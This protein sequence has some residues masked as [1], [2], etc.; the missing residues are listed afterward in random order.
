MIKN[1]IIY[2]VLCGFLTSC[3]NPTKTIKSNQL[4][5]STNDYQQPKIVRPVTKAYINTANGENMIL[6]SQIS[7]NVQNISLLDAI[8][9]EKSQINVIALDD[10][11]SLDKKIS[12]RAN[13]IKFSDYLIQLGRITGYHLTLDDNKVIIASRINQTWNLAALA[14]LPDAQSSIKNKSTQ[15]TQNNNS[16]RLSGDK[17]WLGIV[18]NIN[19]LLDNKTKNKHTAKILTNRRLGTISVTASPDDIS[20]VDNYLQTV[21][22]S[23]NKQI[24]LEITVLDVAIDE[25]ISSGIDFTA[26]NT[27]IVANLQLG[28]TIKNIKNIQSSVNINGVLNLLNTHGKVKIISKP[29]ITLTNGMSSQFG[30]INDIRFISKINANTDQS[31]NV[32]Q[33]SEFENLEIGLQMSVVVRLIDDKRVLVQLVPSV[34]SVVSSTNVTTGSGDNQQTF[35]LPNISLQSLLTQVIVEDGQSIVVGGLVSNKVV[36]NIKSFDHNLFSFL[37][38]KKFEKEHREIFFLVKATILN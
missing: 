3:G 16:I 12:I 13:K 21:I 31:G 8:T 1:I 38:G 11:V 17:E 23:A 10:G 36:D 4:N 34:S 33:T 7:I 29:L 19:L 20:Q 14:S 28:N 22:K 15:N 2:I 25:D 18:N 26:L 24:T 5:N 30:G 6:D 27:G 32:V 35:Q 37:D 9:K